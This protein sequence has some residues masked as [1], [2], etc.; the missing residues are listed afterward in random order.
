LFRET[1]IKKLDAAFN[2]IEKEIKGEETER[3][4]SDLEVL[5]SFELFVFPNMKEVDTPFDIMLPVTQADHFKP[6]IKTN[7]W[8]Y[9][10][11]FLG[12]LVTIF[13]FFWGMI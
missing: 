7:L 11:M 1:K 9:A 13:T 10:S 8:F 12:V 2:R 6:D 4:L 5:R 3:P